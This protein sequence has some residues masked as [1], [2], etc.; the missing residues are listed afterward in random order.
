MIEEMTGFIVGAG[1]SKAYGLPTGL[2]LRQEIFNMK[3]NS[4]YLTGILDNNWY[5]KEKFEQFI[6]SFKNS[7]LK[8]IDRFLDFH[9]EYEKEGKACIAF[10]IK[11]H[12]LSAIKE[13][14]KEEWLL[15]LYDKLTEGIRGIFS[16]REI[17]NNRVYITTFNYDRIIEYFLIKSYIHSF[18]NDNDVSIKFSKIGYSE[19]QKYYGF[20]ID[21]IYGMIGDLSINP[22]DL[23][24]GSLVDKSYDKINIIGERAINIVLVKERLRLCK[25]I[26][27]LGYG[28][29]L[30]N[31][32]LL[33]LKK[34]LNDK[35]IYGTC[36]GLLPEEISRINAVFDGRATLLDC[37]CNE[38]LRRFL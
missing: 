23:E 24:D 17:Q 4:E 3:P 38:L 25:R 2:E 26:F 29:D 21:H 19:F 13:L 28:F 7:G 11:Q 37:D 6:D 20:Y 14:A 9:P 30:Y 34:T 12:E 8:S 36:F 10:L 32:D 15:K 35:T 1:A 27:F 33:E 22:I 16:A 5:K 31:N 18:S